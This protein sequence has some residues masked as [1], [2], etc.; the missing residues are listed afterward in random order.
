MSADQNETVLTSVS[1]AFKRLS[2][3]LSSSPTST[4]KT[5][6][7][8]TPD[9][10]G[11]D[12]PSTPQ[13]SNTAPATPSS[14]RSTVLNTSIQTP[15]K[16]PSS[17]PGQSKYVTEQTPSVIKNEARQLLKKLDSSIDDIKGA[18]DLYALCLF[19]MSNYC[20]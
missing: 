20:I 4:E 8:Y 7:E 17:T 3:T 6:L 11:N 18:E 2:T 16:F 5:E 19:G 9:S 13:Q 15:I 12:V 10:T 1:N 14:K